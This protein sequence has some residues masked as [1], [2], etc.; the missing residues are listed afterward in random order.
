MLIPPILQEKMEGITNSVEG[1]FTDFTTPI[2]TK[3]VGEMMREA[4]IE[5][6]RMIS[7]NNALIE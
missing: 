2:I 7:G 3:I 6:H 4:L 5:L 1:L